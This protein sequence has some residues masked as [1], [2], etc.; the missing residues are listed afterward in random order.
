MESGCGRDLAGDQPVKRHFEP[1]AV[2]LNMLVAMVWLINGLF[3]KL[4]NF[5]PRHREIVAEILGSQHAGWMTN[6]I[7]VGE[8]LLALWILSWR[9]PRVVAVIQILLVAAMNALELALVPDLLLWGPFNV[10]FAFVF[11]VAVFCNGFLLRAR[12]A[13]P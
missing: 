2:I 8:V 10:L 7:G 13:P 5:V 12:Q 9:F 11:I 3:A 1:A 4:L 6:A